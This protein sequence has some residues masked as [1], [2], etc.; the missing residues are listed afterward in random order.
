MIDPLI[1]ALPYIPLVFGIYLS[2][3]IF[4][5]TD[6]TADG[7]FVLGGGL[8]A[9]LLLSGLPYGVAILG[10]LMGG[11]SVGLFLA[12]LQKKDRMPALLASIICVFML[13]SLSLL[14]MG[15][16]NLTLLLT[17]TPFD[18][19]AQQ[20]V[21]LGPLLLLGVVVFL[22]AMLL[23]G[24]RTQAGLIARAFGV[25]QALLDKRGVHVSLIRGLGLGISNALYA[26][27]GILCVHVQ[28]FADINM[29]L[30][31]ALMGIGAVM[32]GRQFF[33]RIHLLRHHVFCA[34]REIAACLFG[35]C[36][37]LSLIHGVLML[38]LDP[39]YVKLLLGM[40]LIL[41]FLIPIHGGSN[42]LC[43]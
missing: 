39:L 22:V 28:K 4:K 14:I 23:L 19:V 15:Q 3:Q 18:H 10:G 38:G 31:V 2:F 13:Y 9:K 16:P 26:L 37:Y 12:L 40:I 27:S 35:I 24:L 33:M 11:F 34:P 7:S 32:I 17:T 5:I 20:H 8:Y 29:G 1:Q 42:V 36:T 25:N 6:L 41:A 21:L 30:G 43:R